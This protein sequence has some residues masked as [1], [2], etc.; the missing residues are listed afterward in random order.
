MNWII[1]NY[2][3]IFSGIGIFI[4]GI[5]YNFFRRKKKQRIQKSSDPNNQVTNKLKA[6]NLNLNQTIITNSTTGDLKTEIDKSEIIKIANNELENVGKEYYSS[7][8]KMRMMIIKLLSDIRQENSIIEVRTITDK[9]E[10]DLGIDQDVTFHELEKIEEEGLIKFDLSDEHSVTP[11][12][13]IR[14]T[15]KFFELLK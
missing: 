4:L 13:R 6:K 11:Y 14:F 10:D 1:D 5:L 12:S 15:E 9:A 2:Q 8:N 3:W 7:S